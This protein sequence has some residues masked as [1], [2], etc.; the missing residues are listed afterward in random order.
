MKITTT[1]GIRFTGIC[2]A[3]RKLGC[4]KAHL[5]YILTGER[6]SKRIRSRAKELGIKLP[7]IP[8][9]PRA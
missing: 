8:A 4:S 5:H 6:Q 7:R 1:Q 9:K 3:A 2:E